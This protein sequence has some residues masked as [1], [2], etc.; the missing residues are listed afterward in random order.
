[1]DIID[2]VV[3]SAARRILINRFLRDAARAAAVALA[4]AFFLRAAE[5]LADAPIHWPIV[6]PALAAAALLAAAVSTALAKPSRLDAARALDHHAGLNE[7]LGTAVACAE[8]PGPWSTLV[9]ATARDHAASIRVNDALP[10]RAPRHLAHAVA[11]AVLL[12]ILWIS[13]PA[14][15][16]LAPTP[17]TPRDDKRLAQAV[18][19][20]EEADKAL[21]QLIERLAPEDRQ[22]IAEADDAENP[23]AAPPASLDAADVQRAE[24][25]RL[26][27]LEQRLEAL[28]ASQNAQTLAAQRAAAEKLKYPG[29]GPLDNVFK[30]L[31]RGEFSKASDALESLKDQLAAN[32]FDP[33]QLND[34]MAQLDNLAA[35]LNDQASDAS[36]LADALKA[37]GLDADKA[38]QLAKQLLDKSTS[39]PD[40]LAQLPELSPEDLARLTQLLQALLDSGVDLQ[41]LAKSFQEMANALSKEDIEALA[42]ALQQ[43][44]ECAQCMGG[45]E[46]SQKAAQLALAQAR[47]R[48]NALAQSMGKPGSSPGP[49]TGVGLGN[50][51]SAQTDPTPPP[52]NTTIATHLAP[53]TNTGGPVIH[54][55]LVH[56]ESVRGESRQALADAV[57]SA[58]K[59]AAQSI[60]NNAVSPDL[61]PAVR[62][63]FSR[64]E[65]KTTTAPAPPK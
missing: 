43:A 46:G 9:L 64:L 60:Q 27:S 11:A 21:N 28:A 51:S 18:R 2:R 29:Q 30:Q 8:R 63:Y 5:R 17:A 42:K 50:P 49:G 34:L 19:D 14:Y 47:A 38:A 53:S 33:E 54:S 45:R 32:E 6:A 23:D 48:M 3:S 12:L 59:S 10:I 56:G 24:L 31:A 62:A 25:K 22:A 35:Q 44:G 41:N 15:N 40:A 16:L 65:K 61:H 20:R 26:E 4:A 58:S 13:L 36:A 1:M 39:L 55:R 7:S 52:A 57:Q 37:S